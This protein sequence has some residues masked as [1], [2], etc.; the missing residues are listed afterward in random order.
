MLKIDGTIDRRSDANTSFKHYLPSLCSP[1]VH[2]AVADPSEN[3][4]DE[5]WTPVVVFVAALLHYWLLFSQLADLRKY[6]AHMH[7]GGGGGGIP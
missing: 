1:V 2:V 3:V 7:P 5:A 4:A 6:L